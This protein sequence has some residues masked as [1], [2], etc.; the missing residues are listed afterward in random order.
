MLASGSDD[1]TIR[2]WNVPQLGDAASFLC[3]SVG[4]SP[5]RERWQDL[6]PRAPSTARSAGKPGPPREGRSRWQS[7]LGRSRRR[8]SLRDV[9]C[10]GGTATALWWTASEPG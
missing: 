4:Q 6:V 5:T 8:H 1:M 9:D 2:L 10:E 7:F 3:K